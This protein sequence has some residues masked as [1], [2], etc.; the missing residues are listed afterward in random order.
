[1][2]GIA[3][4]F[5]NVRP[6]S[7]TMIGILFASVT[8]LLFW[9][10][11]S[12]FQNLK[13]SDWI[14]VWILL[15]IAGTMLVGMIAHNYDKKSSQSTLNLNSAISLLGRAAEVIVIDSKLTNDRVAWVT[16]ARLIS[17]AQMIKDQLSTDT[18]KLVFEAEHDYQ[19]HK[20]RELLRPGRNDL[21]GAFFCGSEVNESI[22]E[23]V[24]A[25]THPP[26]G[27]NWIPPRIVKVVYDFISFPED[28]EDPLD[29]SE[30]Y[31]KKERQRLD[32]TGYE[33]V[34]DYLTFRENFFAVGNKIIQKNVKRHEPVTAEVIDSIVI[35]EKFGSDDD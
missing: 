14:Q 20:F 12:V 10:G 15:C 4:F 29:A 24:T 6:L 34:A 22:G 32:R 18:H 35:Y 28:Y 23:A 11:I 8:L 17:R 30:P 1:M 5:Q 25:P 16:C 21:S 19:R 13:E 3:H 7:A 31:S 27:S 33:G 26:Y 2:S 9:R